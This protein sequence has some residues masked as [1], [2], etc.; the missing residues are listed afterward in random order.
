MD[1]H[2]WS[3]RE[4]YHLLDQLKEFKE[5]KQNAK[6][7]KEA[8]RALIK[9][10][11]FLASMNSEINPKDHSKTILNSIQQAH[12]AQESGSVDK[13]YDA[14]RY[15]HKE[16]IISS[17]DLTNHFKSNN[18]VGDI[19]NNINRIC[20]KHHCKILTEHCNKINR[21]EVINHQ[22][23]KFDC[24]AEYLEH[25]KDNV[26]HDMLPVKQMNKQIERVHEQQRDRGDDHHMSLDM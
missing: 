5:E 1:K 20:Y 23:H 3:I 12:E 18:P 24:V 26:H 4:K 11:E 13:L 22:G 19:H 7:P 14:A 16:K 8:M 17:H 21:G 15:A 25:W 6:T 2:I 10:Q 9:E